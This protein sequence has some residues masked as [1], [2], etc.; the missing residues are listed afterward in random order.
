MSLLGRLAQ[1]ALKR[2]LGI[3]LRSKLRSKSLLKRSAS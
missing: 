1:D 2:N 3:D